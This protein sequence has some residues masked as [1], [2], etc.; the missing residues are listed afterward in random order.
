MGESS[1]ANVPVKLPSP[2]WAWLRRNPVALKELRGRMRGPRAFIVLTVYILLMSI[3][4]VLLYAIYTASAQTTLSTTG[5]VIGKVIFGG[6]LSIELFLVCF[7]APAFTS[8]AV[9]G[10]RERRTYHILRTTLLSA[11]RLIWGKLLA[12]MTYVVLLLLVAVPLQSIAFLM[13]G[14]TISEVLL[15]VEILIV[16]GLAYGAIG[17]YFST[18]TKRTLSASVLTYSIALLLTIALPLLTFV[19]FTFISAMLLTASNAQPFA[20]ALLFAVFAVLACTNP[21][22]TA[23]LTEVTLQQSGSAF[24][25]SQTLPIGISL[26]LPSPWIVFTVVYLLVTLILVRLSVRSVRQVDV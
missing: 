23:I 25:F 24:S 3:F 16:T 6:V 26:Q 12:A 15:S 17:I 20:E 19:L 4:T 10:E 14:V 8:S 13:G 18:V 11:D 22:A 7:I 1:T 21:I 2:L 9:S 5:G